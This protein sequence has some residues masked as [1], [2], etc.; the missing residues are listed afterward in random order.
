MTQV[1]ALWTPE[2][3]ARVTGLLQEI[4]SM[5]TW[6]QDLGLSES[7]TADVLDGYNHLIEQVY[8]S[9][10]QLARLMDESDLVLGVQGPGTQL[11]GSPISVITNLLENAKK[12]VIGVAR[13]VNQAAGKRFPRAYEPEFMGLAPGSI[14]IGVSA[15]EPEKA[16]TLFQEEDPLHQSVQTALEAIGVVSRMIS[17][18]RDIEDI[19]E[20]ITDPVLRDASIRAVQNLAPTSRNGVERVIIA[21]RLVP[22]SKRPTETGEPDHAHR[23]VL[24]SKDRT[25]ARELV[26]QPRKTSQHGLFTG[27]V[28]EIDLDQRR[29]DIR[30]VKELEAGFSLRCVYSEDFDSLAQLW[31]NKVVAVSGKVEHNAEGQPRLL[32]VEAVEVKNPRTGPSKSLLN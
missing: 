29:F 30:R 26:K 14:Y 8:L 10:M 32:F 31:L 22:E 2:I 13:S 24:T 7:Q 18:D 15:P 4:E 28:R 12:Q 23:V 17:D 19:A 6:A 11:K 21:G 27:E 5:R 16:G 9:D 20:V 1:K 25:Q 3:Q